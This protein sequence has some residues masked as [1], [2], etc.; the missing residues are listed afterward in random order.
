MSVS[1]I[2]RK[3]SPLIANPEEGILRRRTSLLGIRTTARRRMAAVSKSWCL[4]LQEGVKLTLEQRLQSTDDG[5]Q[6]GSDQLRNLMECTS[7]EGGDSPV[8]DDR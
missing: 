1:D 4:H 8:Y 7:I 6:K 3:E 5:P 2:I